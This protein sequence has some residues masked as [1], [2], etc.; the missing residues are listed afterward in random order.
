[1]INLAGAAQTGT[2]AYWNPGTDITDDFIS[3]YNKAN[4]VAGGAAPATQPAKP[5]VK[6]PG[7]KP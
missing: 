3:E 5:T 1:V 6:P 2:L 4:P 7:S